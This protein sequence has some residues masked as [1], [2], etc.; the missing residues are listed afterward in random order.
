MQH[1]TCDA[2]RSRSNGPLRGSPRCGVVVF[3]FFLI[4]NQNTHIPVGRREEGG[5]KVGCVS[6]CLLNLF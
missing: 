6:D 4:L 1:T 5:F 2:S 3:S